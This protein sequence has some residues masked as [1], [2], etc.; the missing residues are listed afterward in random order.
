MVSQIYDTDD[1]SPEVERMLAYADARIERLAADRA[2]TAERRRALV[3]PAYKTVVAE[4]AQVHH[5]IALGASLV[6]AGL[7][8]TDADAVAGLLAADALQVL[9]DAEVLIGAEP[10]LSFGQ[11][12]VRL[13][14]LH[15]RELTG[16]G[17][18]ETWCRRLAAYEEDRAAWLARDEQFRLEGAWRREP[19]TAGQRWL[20]R[21]TCRVTGIDLPG[22][23]A[24][25]D[26]ADWLAAHGA[27]VSYREFV[28]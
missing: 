2:L 8:A 13:V 15:H 19:T 28:R 3:A 9:A 27:N 4:P 21:V 20:V 14:D 10:S 12:L 23:L 1:G 24:R 22:H 25:G 26:A 18:Y 6:A 17:L 7:A 11:A 5:K 16:R